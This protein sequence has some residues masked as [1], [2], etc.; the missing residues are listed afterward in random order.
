MNIFKQLKAYEHQLFIF[1]NIGNGSKYSFQLA[2]LLFFRKEYHVLILFFSQVFACFLFIVYN[3]HEFALQL[4]EYK[5]L[6]LINTES[7]T[8]LISSK[9]HTHSF[10]EF[11]I[12]IKNKVIDSYGYICNKVD[13]ESCRRLS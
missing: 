1:R 3:W 9:V 10:I 7:R 8:L 5:L 13:C 6:E 4:I 2:V 12:Y 11:K